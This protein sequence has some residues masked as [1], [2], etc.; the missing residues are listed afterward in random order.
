GF[1]IEIGEVESALLDHP[2]VAEAAVVARDAGATKELVAFVVP[3]DGVDLVASQLRESLAARLPDYMLPTG[4]VQLEALPLTPSGK[5][6]RKKLAKMQADVVRT[7]VEYVAP[8]TETE[9][10]LQ[11]IWQRVLERDSIGVRDNFFDAGGHSLLAI[12]LLNEI[13]EEFGK[14]VPLVQLFQ[15]PTIEGLAEYL[16]SDGRATSALV[17]FNDP[18]EGTPLFFIHPSGGSVHWYAELARALGPDQPFFGIKAQGADGEAPFHETIEEMAAHAVRAMRSRQAHGPY[19]FGSWS[20]GVVIAYEAA[21]QLVREGEE[22]ALLAM[23]DQGPDFPA[24]VPEDDTEFLAGMFGNRLKFNV[25][26]LRRMPYEKQLE[27]VLKKAKKARLL[28]PNVRD[29][30]FGDYVRLLKTE[31]LAWKNYK[32]EPYPGRIVVFRSS[33]RPET[34]DEPW[35]LGWGRLAQG[36]VEVFVVPGNHNTILWKPNVQELAEILQTIVG[37]QR[38]LK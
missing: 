33:E 8:R 10:K 28:P 15:T 2:E 3:A 13:E 27:H 37:A 12:R 16:E 22:V 18:G 23:L 1:R 36:G 21:Q 30:Q 24:S 34:Q 6:D 31:M 32:F 38:T 19:F 5:V 11:A 25:K 17:A 26:K 4:F 7:G 29:E 14:Q 35:D 9:E 20:M